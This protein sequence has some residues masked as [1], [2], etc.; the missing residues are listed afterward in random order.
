MRFLHAYVAIECSLHLCN[1]ASVTGTRHAIMPSFCQL[2]RLIRTSQT[3]TARARFQCGMGHACIFTAGDHDEVEMLSLFTR[4]QQ[5][6]VLHG[7]S[8]IGQASPQT[9]IQRMGRQG[10]PL[11]AMCV[12]PLWPSNKNGKCMHGNARMV[13]TCIAVFCDG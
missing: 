7:E 9:T 4:R 13:L 2:F 1:N 3:S 11:C 5:P 8:N 6:C 12:K 10:S